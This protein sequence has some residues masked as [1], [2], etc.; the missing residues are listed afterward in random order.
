MR[1]LP[2]ARAQAEGRS[3]E[4]TR[5]KRVRDEEGNITTVSVPKR[6]KPWWFTADGGRLCVS[7]NYGSHVLELAKGKTAVEANDLAEV[8]DIQKTPSVPGI[9]PTS[10]RHILDPGRSISVNSNS[11]GTR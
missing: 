7:I 10:L 8:A 1:W 4:I 11:T 2:I 6:T 9:T 5:S 3:F